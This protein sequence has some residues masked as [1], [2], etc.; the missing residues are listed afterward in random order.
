MEEAALALRYPTRLAAGP[1]G[2]VYV[3]DAKQG[4]VLVYDRSG[5]VVDQLRELPGPLGVA[6]DS[7]GK[8]YVGCS[9]SRSVEVLGPGDE[10]SSVDAGNIGLP[11]DLALDRAGNL[12]V[13]DSSADVVR[14][15]GPSGKPRLTIA[16]GGDGVGGLG[17]P[18]AV[19]V[20]Y[21]DGRGELFVADQRHHRVQ[22]FDLDG[23]FLRA[24]GSAAASAGDNWRGRFVRLQSLDV[25]RAGR[26]HAADS[27]LHRVQI[28][29]AETGA[30]VDDYGA[31]GD[32]PGR[33]RLPLDVLLVGAG[34]AWVADAGNGRLV[35]FR[36]P[37]EAEAKE[38]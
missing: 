14:S 5:A 8:V 31:L 9:G 34:E 7:A 27:Y 38:D 15:Y 28:L 4:A 21:R 20:G 24:F 18:S 16:G 25:D 12:Y 30:Y 29:D 33:F 23:G 11:N 26:L 2:R 35:R 37:A 32:G 1:D 22:V 6:V 17:F 3:S 36:W 19:T 13:A 10:R